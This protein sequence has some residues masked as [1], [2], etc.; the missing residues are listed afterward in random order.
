MVRRMKFPLRHKLARM[1]S[2]I[3]VLALQSFLTSCRSPH[4]SD[5]YLSRAFNEN[6]SVF[7][8][9]LAMLSEDR[10]VDRIDY[11]FVTVDGGAFWKPGDPQFPSRDGKNTELSFAELDFSMELDARVMIHQQFSFM[12]GV[13][14]RQSHG[15]ARG[16]HIP[17][18]R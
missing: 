13:A 17:R 18:R 16:T 4:D 14:A 1:I 6:S 2:I 10:H 7:T 5:V 12:P 11:D 15:I 8:R 9:I 3:C